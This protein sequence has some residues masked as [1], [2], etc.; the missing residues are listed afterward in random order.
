MII[1]HEQVGFNP[2]TQGWFNIQK[3]INIIHCID[4]LKDQ[5][6]MMISLDAEKAFDK[7]Q[8]PFIIKSWKDQEF[9]VHT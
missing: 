5:N 8:H 1:D 3:S 4:K 7:I 6:Y 2:G 9:K